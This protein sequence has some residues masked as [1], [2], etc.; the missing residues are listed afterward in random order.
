MVDYCCYKPILD[1]LE[2]EDLIVAQTYVKVMS[3]HALSFE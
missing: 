3:I 1:Y 2:Y